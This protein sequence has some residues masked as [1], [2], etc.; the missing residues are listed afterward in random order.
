MSFNYSVLPLHIRASKIAYTHYLSTSH[1]KKI[2]FSWFL[3]CFPTNV[4]SH[5][6]TSI[7]SCHIHIY[8]LF[9]C[10]VCLVPIS[11]QEDLVACW[12]AQNDV[13]PKE[14]EERILFGFLHT[15]FFV[16]IHASFRL[17]YLL[18]FSRLNLDL[19]GPFHTWGQ[20][21]GICPCVCPLNISW[22]WQKLWLI[23]FYRQDKSSVTS[24]S[25]VQNNISHS[26]L[27]ETS[28]YNLFG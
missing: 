16:H 18:R 14:K 17:D 25:E 27:L 19:S 10:S 1:A 24:C 8:A 21:Q 13:K 20:D 28:P 22:L 2:P 15:P 4:L 12:W 11:L 3:I 9:S 5:H 26:V 7:W 23:Y 6:L